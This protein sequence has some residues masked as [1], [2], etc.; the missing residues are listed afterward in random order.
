MWSDRLAFDPGS[1]A[2]GVWSQATRTFFLSLP[3]HVCTESLPWGCGETQGSSTESSHTASNL[4]QVL[5]PAGSFLVQVRDKATVIFKQSTH[6]V[7]KPGQ[8][9]PIIWGNFVCKWAP[10]AVINTNPIRVHGHS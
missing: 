9:F 4:G 8:D 3:F 1:T 5:I 10:E 2:P 7:F 6:Q